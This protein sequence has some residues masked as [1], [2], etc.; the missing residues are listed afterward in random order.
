MRIRNKKFLIISLTFISILALSLIS[1]T[2]VNAL[3]LDWLFGDESEDAAKFLRDHSDWL[4]FGSFLPLILHELGWLVVKSVYFLTSFMEGLVSDSID[5]LDFLDYAGLSELGSSI[6]GDLVVVLMVLTIVF[7]GI[8][9]IV[10]KEPPNFKNVGVNIFISAFLVLGLPELMNTMEEVS[11]GFFDATQESDGG[12]E[13]LSW[14]L[15][16]DN[17]A[18]LF[19]IADNGFELIEN[20]AEDTKKNNLNPDLFKA[21][22]MTELI[23]PEVTKEFDGDASEMKYLGY[24][25]SNDGNGNFTATEIKNGMMSWFSDSF[26]SGYFRY[27]V[28]FTPIIV[29][30]LALL[31]AYLFATFVFVTTIIEIGVKQ[32]VANIVFAT[33]LE[34]GQKTKMV[35]KDIMSAFM[36]IAFTGLGLKIYTI[37]LS[38]L[39]SSDVNVVLYIIAIVSATFFMIRGSNTL[40]KYFGID[41]GIKDGFGQLMGAFAL[42]KGAA[43]LG[44]GVSNMFKR[45][46]GRFQDSNM[47]RL[48]NEDSMNSINGS[49]EGV[50]NGKKGL[51]NSIRNGANTAGKTIG[52]MGNRGLTGMAEDAVKGTASKLYTSVNDKIG[53][54]KGGIQSIKDGWQ[55]GQFEGEQK[56]VANQKKWENGLSEKENGTPSAETSNQNIPEHAKSGHAQTAAI[57]NHIEEYMNTAPNGTGLTNEEI[58]AKMKLDEAVDPNKNQELTRSIKDQQEGTDSVRDANGA[59]SGKGQTNEEI[60]RNIKLN[61]QSGIGQKDGDIQQTVSLKEQAGNGQ[62]NDEILKNVKLE[63]AM[64]QEIGDAKRNV[65]NQESGSQENDANTVANSIGNGRTN[66]EI[67][68]KMKVDEV[69]SPSNSEINGKVNA[70]DSGTNRIVQDT[71]QKV[72][73]EIDTSSGQV[74]T[75]KQN[76]IQEVQS[77]S[78]TTDDVKQR[79]IQEIQSAGSA[80]PQQLEQNVE[81]VLSDY[82]ISGNTQDV[83]QKVIQE[84]QGGDTTPEIAKAKVVEEIEKA[85]GFSDSTMKQNVIQDIQKAFNATPEQLEQ[86]IKQSIQ[87]VTAP[88][89]QEVTNTVVE[90]RITKSSGGKKYFGNLGG[91]LFKETTPIKKSSRFDALKP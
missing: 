58:L 26:D 36:L 50:A 78:S 72:A 59:I 73:R 38:Y 24:T 55:D 68:A 82:R 47:E 31:V 29:G 63:E 44:K 6:I 1:P 42:G 33:D 22:N 57:P 5:M 34:S 65:I 51:A 84:V 4:Q 10:S 71:L 83:V 80:T 17:T 87:T 41:T 13:S 75:I 12:T 56:G 85:A 90:D 53:S 23:T 67:L 18:D 76:I 69:I 45:G 52:Y 2:V 48:A 70:A 28:K 46:S 64:Q 43:G 11:V 21:S 32:I 8:K 81:Q 27:P 49:S 15:I 91:D 7:L 20:G 25:L 86:N 60:L 66:D 62:T 3:S 89:T 30:L 88:R 61:E 40:M 35:V 54:V 77:D 9:T 79:V 16:E 19:Y 14:G 74:E 39:A 37:F